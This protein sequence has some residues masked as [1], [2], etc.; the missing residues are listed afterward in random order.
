MKTFIITGILI[1]F[2]CTGIYSIKDIVND[3]SHNSEI[4]KQ[5]DNQNQMITFPDEYGNSKILSLNGV[6]YAVPHNW[7]FG[8]LH[9]A[10]DKQVGTK[11]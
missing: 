8:D 2:A 3:K 9:K 11:R 1:L 4:S 7:T 6:A 5:Y 10:I